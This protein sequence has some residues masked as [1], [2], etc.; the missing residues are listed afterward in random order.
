MRWLWRRWAL[1]FTPVMSGVVGVLIGVTTAGAT[2]DWSWVL[3]G[4]FIGL[5]IAV[6]TASYG[7]ARYW[8]G[9]RDGFELSN[10]TTAFLK[11]QRDHDT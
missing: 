8:V 10:L 3:W 4:V 1:W 6:S 5:C 11:K 9:H 7:K 2:K